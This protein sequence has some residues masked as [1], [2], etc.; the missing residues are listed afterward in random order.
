MLVFGTDG[1]IAW[2]LASW[3]RPGNAQKVA[4]NNNAAFHI[5][6]NQPMIKCHLVKQRIEQHKLTLRTAKLHCVIII[7]LLDALEWHSR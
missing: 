2:V 3:A 1:S 6:V 7:V 4:T 5:E